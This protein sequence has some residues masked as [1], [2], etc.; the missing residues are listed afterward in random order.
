MI[1]F[2]CVLICLFVFVRRRSGGI[3]GLLSAGL[4]LLTTLYMTY[5]VEARSYSLVTACVAIALVD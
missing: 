4:A 2:G 5:A 1:G 3:Y